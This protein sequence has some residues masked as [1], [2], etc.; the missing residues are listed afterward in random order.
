M[1]TNRQVQNRRSGDGTLASFLASKK[2]QLITGL[3]LWVVGLYICLYATSPVT[4]SSAQE[5]MFRERLQ[6]ASDENDHALHSALFEVNRM[7]EELYEVKVWFWRF[8]PEYRDE[9]YRVQGYL[10]QALSRL[11]AVEA[12]K[13]AMEREARGTVGIWS[14]Y[15]LH[16]ARTLFWSCY[17]RGKDIAK[18]H[19]FFDALFTVGRDDSL[20]AFALRMAVT[21]II[22]STFGM[23]AA[24][25][26]FMWEL[27]SL[28]VAYQTSLLS[29]LLFFGLALLG[30]VSLVSTYLFLLTGA[31]AGAGYVLVSSVARSSVTGAQPR[32][33]LD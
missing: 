15:G 20:V 16:D 12:K 26:V 3:T 30:A 11:Y 2:P 19:T 22:N 25:M 33:H 23:F 4:I 10:D 6:E 9:V 13:A 27:W 31:V 1:D 21:F 18:R 24:I 32:Y 17:E 8:R 5:A 29:G 7:Q 28:L 14:H